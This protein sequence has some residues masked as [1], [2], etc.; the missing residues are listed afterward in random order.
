M[1]EPCLLDN[2]VVLKVAAYGLNDPMLELL[3]L[4]DQAPAMLGVGRFVVRQKTVRF[5]S[6]DLVAS[7]LE[8]L[9]DRLQVIEPTEAEIELA[10]DFEAAALQTGDA[11]DTGEAQLV[12]VL[13]SRSSPALVTGDKRAIEALANLSVTAAFNRII[14]LEQ[15][16]SNLVRRGSISDLRAKVCSKPLVDQALTNCFACASL[17]IIELNADAAISALG[18]YVDYLRQRSKVVLMANSD[19]LALTA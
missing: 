4:E 19:V 7:S 8:E 1:P 12:A 3:T 9:L 2:D 17:G 15:M 14:C 18:S 10:A 11:F 6:P 13:V 16:F 5:Q